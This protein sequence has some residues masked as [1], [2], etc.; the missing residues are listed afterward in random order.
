MIKIE[1][2]DNRVTVTGHAG[3]GPPGEDIVCASISTLLQTLL[4]SLEELAGD[5]IKTRQ[6]HGEAGI[7]YEH[8]DLSESARL[9]IESFFIGVSGVAEAAPECVAV[10]DG[11]HGTEAQGCADKAMVTDREVQEGT[12]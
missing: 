2:T 9:L 12:E 4:A 5:R 7:E 10:I 11:R 8:E 1:L 6:R 3:A